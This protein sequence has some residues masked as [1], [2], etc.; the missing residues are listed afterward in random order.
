M[1]T[2]LRDQPVFICGHPKAGTSLVRS[3]LDSH[4]QLIVYPEETVF[5]RRFL[6]ESADLDLDGMTALAE[7]RIIHIFD[8]EQ[9]NPPSNQEGFPDRDYTT[10]SS[11]KV[12]MAMRERVQAGY[13]HPGDIL[14]AAV[15]A[16]GQV[17]GLINPEIRHWVEKSPYNEYYCEQIYNWWP[18]AQCIHIVRDPRDNYASYRQKHPDW[19]AEF[20]AANWRRS[21][22]SGI[23][24]Q[25]RFGKAHYFLLKYEDLTYDPER[26]LKKLAEFLD[27]DWDVSL[28]TPSRAGENWLGNSMFA[29]EFKGISTAP[30]SR[31]VERLAP[32][33]TAVIELMT[34][35]QMDAF[36]YQMASQGRPSQSLA[37]RWRVTTWPVRRHLQRL[38]RSAP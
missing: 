32:G 31:W 29:N 35:A 30:V 8:W 18:Q 4:P 16:F 33:D 26:H 1:T 20:F 19:S 37:A 15:L 25:G 14:S 3:I 21:T 38:S 2:E 23:H 10:I 28:T 22:Q 9:D 6:P 12:R 7:E 24:N 13:R 34:Q 27:I 36:Q 17:R 11:E 5:F